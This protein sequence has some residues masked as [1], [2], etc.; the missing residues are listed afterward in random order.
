MKKLSFEKQVSL[1]VLFLLAMFIL[2]VIFKQGIFSNIAWIV[3]GLAFLI[4]PVYPQQAAHSKHTKTWARI[5]G[6][7]CLL[8]GVL[9]RF[10]V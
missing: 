7:L 3:Y 4:N 10:G 1:G 2:S 6:A 9:T 5:G 8:V